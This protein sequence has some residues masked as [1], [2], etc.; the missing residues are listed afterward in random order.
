LASSTN[1]QFIHNNSGIE[2]HDNTTPAPVT[3]QEQRAF[4][5]GLRHNEH[6]IFNKGR[7][8]LL[9]DDAFDLINESAQTLPDEVLLESEVPDYPFVLWFQT[10]YKYSLLTA[11]AEKL[12][13]HQ[14]E[15]WGVRAIAFR[16]ETKIGRIGEDSDGPG[17]TMTLY[18]DSECL[19]QYGHSEVPS[20]LK[21]N[22]LLVDMLPMRF[23][24]SWWEQH[25][26]SGATWVR[27][28]KQWVVAMFRLMGDHIEREPVHLDRATSRREQRRGRP[29][30]GYLTVLRLRK[31]IY[32]N[33]GDGGAGSS[34]TF[35]HLV[36]G[37][38][39]KFY[40]P[41]A[42]KPVGDPAA[43]RHRYVNN[44]V[45]GPKD[46]EFVPSAQVISVSR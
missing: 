2:V 35:R 15:D 3:A 18:A 16:R 34:A 46:A 19:L 29:A 37:H 17:L 45:R 14:V 40:C 32:T 5:S 13:I 20:H 4:A 39:R 43:Y 27:D 6:H 11:D 30:D 8:V 38:W 7:T 21:N 41:S 23:N 33:H 26:K 1:V 42:Q 10:P 12:G 44:Y 28:L 36:R 22:L 9:T 24:L 31:V 25:D